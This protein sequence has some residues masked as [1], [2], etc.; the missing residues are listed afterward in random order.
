[1]RLRVE[2]GLCNRIQAILGYR[3]KHGPLTV[4]WPLDAIVA[5]ES[6]DLVLQPIEGVSFVHEGPH[7][8]VDYAP[9]KDAPAWWTEHYWAIRP[10]MQMP[11]MPGLYDAVHVRR[12]DFHR[13][14][15]KYHGADVPT[16]IEIAAWAD[17]TTYPV[18]IATDNAETQAKWRR[19]LGERAHVW[20]TIATGTEEQ[21]EHNR[22]R[23]TGLAHAVVDLFMCVGAQR[24]MGSTAHSTFTLTV[25]RIRDLG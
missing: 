17:E 13:M 18:W 22:R 14:I 1:M 9:P 16:D 10:K 20:Q 3:A 15:K 25:E 4:V 8:V 11:R 5:H 24:F 6:F 12:T 7:D 19:V 23:H 21:D 2:G